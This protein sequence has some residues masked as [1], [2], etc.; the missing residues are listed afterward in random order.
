MPETTATT[1]VI[2]LL[3]AIFAARPA[4][5][6][7]WPQWCG[8]DGK[9]MVSLERGLPES[10]VPGEKRGKEGTIDPATA[11]NVRWGV[12]ICDA[13]YSTPSV[14]GGKVLIGGVEGHDGI[15]AGLEAASGKILW[16]WKAPPKEVPHT[17]NGFSIGISGIPQQLGVCST[18]AIDGDRAYLVSNRFEVLCLDV[19][20]QP[21]GP[22]AGQARVVWSYDMW[23]KLGVFPCDAA[24]G[25]PLVDGDLVYVPTSNGVDRN[26]F[27]DTARERNRK[28]PAPKAPNLIVLDKRTG[29]LVATDG[30][31]IAAQIL[32]GQWSSPS[33]GKVG[34]RKLIFF[35]AGDGRCYAFEA[36]A[37]VPE[38][39]VRLKTV[40]SCD[41]IPP[42]YRPAAGV[43]P[44][45]QYC[46]GDKRVHGTLNK[47]DGTFVGP[48]EIIATPVFVDNR[49]YVSHRPRPGARPR[50]RG[51]ALPRRDARRRH[52]LKRT[53]LDLPGVGPD[54]LHGLRLRGPSLCFRRGRPAALPRCPDR[55]VL[56]G[57]RR[58]VRNL[59]L[60]A[61]GR[62]KGL[63]AH[64]QRPLD[65]GGR[66]G[67]AGSG[68]D[69]RR[70]PGD[71]LA[72]GGQRHALHRIHRRLAL[73]GPQTIRLL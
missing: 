53:P 58:E 6:A 59:G 23:D 18:A 12:K 31:D 68:P 27:R 48:S 61:G 35:G 26:T 21:P 39:P 16:R 24:N 45:T 7:D 38:K 2:C 44:V 65:L 46:L 1:A 41:C 64:L 62:W 54:A 72:G 10:F 34:S 70:R 32:H 71:G 51:P 17:I 69:H 47:H 73:G 49:I 66:Q 50:S 14:A 56:L 22:A 37:S 25:S 9:N 13:L 60:D 40:W 8:T 4:L 52:H 19:N 20:G 15:F 67:S 5:A 3:G 42:E 43:E 11:K 30:L 55:Q 29:R 28:I 33:L 63:H 36:L 57:P